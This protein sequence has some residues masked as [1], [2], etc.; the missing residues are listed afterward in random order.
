MKKIVIIVVVLLAVGGLAY[1]SYWYVTRNGKPEAAKP[2]TAKVE[3]GPIK[4]TVAAT[5][6]IV[7]NLDVDIKCK[8]GGTIVKLPF[9]IS[10]HVKDKELLMELDTVDQQRFADQ[11][12]IQVD[13]STAKLEVAKQNLA[14]AELT[15]ATDTARAQAT[16][17]AAEVQARDARTKAD[18]QKQLLDKLLASQEDCDTAQTAAVQAA[19]D[20]ENAQTKLR[21]LKT[22]EQALELQRQNVK[23]AE[24]ALASDKIAMKQAEQGVTDTKVL[25]PM[26]GVVVARS[27]QLGMIIASAMTNVG[28]GTTVL[29]I[30]D[31]SRIFALAAVDEADIGNV[32]VGQPATVTVDAYKEKKFRGKV[33]RIAPMGV[34]ANNVVT[35]EVKVEVVSEDKNLLK[36]MMTANTEITT[37]EKAD[38]LLCP[39]DSVSRRKGKTQVNV[40]KA[41]GT[42]EERPVETGVTDGVKT[43]IASGLSEGETVL[44][45]K[46]ESESK[47]R[48][49]QKG[50]QGAPSPARMMG[51]KR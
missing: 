15:L 48:P 19:S 34:N 43:E 7:S 35:F 10:D 17:K 31:L 8:A 50:Q 6:K 32:R 9:D 1:G 39:S 47:F 30:S 29:T 36:P 26:D 16:L 28:G 18:R 40:V 5:G 4:V 37:A 21:E 3:R 49:D 38:A 45:R 23:L 46:P 33:V 11:S 24:A 27:V 13:S 12:K 14:I 44:V 20:L 41:D 25:A 42:T 2:V 22:Q 51:G